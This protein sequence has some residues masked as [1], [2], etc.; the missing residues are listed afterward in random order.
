MAQWNPMRY[1]SKKIN[2][3]YGDGINTFLPPFDIKES[4][5]TDSLNMCSDDY[6]AIK[7]RNDRTVTTLPALAG[8]KNAIGQRNSS[9]I[10]VLD[11]TH[12]YYAN[13]NSTAWTQLSSSIGDREGMFVEFN[14]EATRY[15]ILANAA[16]TGQINQ[17]YDGTTTLVSLTSNAPHSALYTVHKYRVYGIE[18][19][20]RTLKHSAQGSITNWITSLDAGAIDLTNAKGPATAIT[21][22]ADHVIV[23]T[24][25]S[26]HELYGSNPYNHE[27]IDL[28]NDVGCVNN[29][30][31]IEC[32]GR[33]YW[34]DYNGIYLYAGGFPKLISDKV[35]KWINGI[36]WTVKSKIWA[37]TKGDKIYFG[38]PYKSTAINLLIV[39][40]TYKDKW[41]TQDGNWVNGVTISDVFYGLNNDGRIWNMESTSATG[42]DNST[43]ITWNFETKAYNDFALDSNI[44][45]RDMWVVH[46]GS[47]SA[48]MAIGYSTQVNST[49][50]TTLVNSTDYTHATEPT[51]EQ[52]IIPLDKLQNAEWYRLKFSGAGHKSI[53]AVQ[54]NTLSYGG[55]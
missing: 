36:D 24:D 50:F 7:T 46:S 49:S 40:D 25:N 38:I 29:K 41:F 10:H 2:R 55:D 4:E 14:T 44:G 52:T 43:A 6:P 26:M 3:Q 32:R 34:M 45:V 37:G 20:G 17:A 30:A 54:L 53:Q 12:W 42:N 22:Y 19:N 48:T 28:T 13:T 21:T 27:L 31:K 1:K 39:Y 15:T 11:G 51:K 16:T 18:E 35:K 5:L 9:T 23:W 47:T 33:L 8:N